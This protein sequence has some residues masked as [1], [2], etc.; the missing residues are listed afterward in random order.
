MAD[1]AKIYAWTSLTAATKLAE[2]M[3]EL[4]RVNGLPSCYI[5]PIALGDM[6]KLVNP[7]RIL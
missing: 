1:S 7:L 5:R 2:A 3:L 4:V 6:V